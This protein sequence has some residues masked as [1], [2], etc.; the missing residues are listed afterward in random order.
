MAGVRRRL[1]PLV[2]TLVL[3]ACSA[4]QVDIGVGV[5][6][7]ADGSGT[8]QVS[9]TLDK[10]AAAQA[11]PL[12]LDDLKKAGWRV[13]GPSATASGGQIVRVSKPFRDPAELAR[14]VAE[15]SGQT[16]PFH[17]FSLSRR[18]S[19]FRTT[20]RFSGVVDL[21]SGVAGFTDQDL[22]QR[23]GADSALDPAA[24][25]RVTR[26]RLNQLF[27]FAVTARLPGSVQTSNAPTTAGNGAVWK[28]KF[29]ERI[30]MN[31]TSRAYNTGP[32]AFTAL[33]VVAALA[34]LAVFAVRIVRRRRRPAAPPAPPPAAP[35]PNVQ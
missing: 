11:G 29:G 3:L 28:P 2:A 16:G 5:D 14:V 23:L 32:V 34:L 13:D 12:A 25:E 20:T 9:A 22:Q 33:A 26:A 24:V 8:V 31:A 30:A 19:F 35:V 21:S 1:L 4:C 10:E 6:A 27:A 7:K 17:D 18:R 15:V